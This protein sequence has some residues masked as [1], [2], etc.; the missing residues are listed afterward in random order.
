MIPIFINWKHPSV[1]F[2][3]YQDDTIGHIRQRSHG[4]VDILQL[5]SK[6]SL[7]SSMTFLTADIEG[8][9]W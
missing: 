7:Q 1:H 8:T 5:Y 9:E 6:S 4:E 3:P 2:W